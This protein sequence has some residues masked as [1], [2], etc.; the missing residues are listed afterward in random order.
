MDRVEGGPDPSFR[1]SFPWACSGTNKQGRGRKVATQLSSGMS[2]AGALLTAHDAEVE[3][4]FGS[5]NG[6][7]R[8]TLY[9]RHLRENKSE[10]WW[11]SC[12]PITSPRLT[13]SALIFRAPAP[14]TPPS[15]SQAEMCGTWPPSS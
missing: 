4:S 7:V 13:W 9:L 10:R 8:G 1:S 2:F 11:Q 6:G 12:N 14:L 15:S 5:P 3:S